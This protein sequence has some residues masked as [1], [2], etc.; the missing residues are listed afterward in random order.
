M[1]L[2]S[3]VPLLADARLLDELTAILARAAAT[4][5]ALAPGSL[6]PRSKT[7][8]SPV[9]AADEAAEA[10]ILDHL[11]RLIPGVPVVSEE[12]VAQSDPPALTSIFALVDPLDGTRELIAGRPEFTINLAIVADCAPI[13]GLIAAPA[14]GLLWRGIVGRRAERLRLAGATAVE[15][16]PIRTRS[17]PPGGLVAALSRSHLDAET[18]SFTDRLPVA[19][20]K[21]CGSA[22]KFCRVAEGTADI[23][24]RLSPTSEWDVAAGH[25]VLVAAGGIVAT[26][27]GDP[28]RYGR[29]RERFRVPAFIAWGDRE[30]ASRYRP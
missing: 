5:L 25:A 21:L 7:D 10:V 20:R 4:V 24:P 18:A 9:T 8:L 6:A 28:V 14:L 27:D 22:V 16:A 11:S 3:A 29:A 26:P 30:A 19:E 15:P 17:P 12:Q 13:V 2:D 23:Y 1:P